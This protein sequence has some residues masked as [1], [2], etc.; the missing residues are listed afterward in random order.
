MP[1]I[2]QIRS[3]AR[4]VIICDGRLLATKMRDARGVYYILPGGGQRP[5]ETLEE[6]VRREC[7]EEAGVKVR[8]VRLLYVREYIGK[9]HDFSKRH[10]SFHQLEHVFLCEVED[11]RSACP[12]R[13]TD[14]HQIG[15][16]WLA[17]EALPRIR[18]YPEAVK[19]FLGPAGPAFPAAYLGDCN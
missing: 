3:A 18:F 13:E 8:V 4:A 12:G 19:P 16:N 15:V 6:T 1:Q 7:L 14:T 5:G 11:P 9:N 17:L 2:R 10:A